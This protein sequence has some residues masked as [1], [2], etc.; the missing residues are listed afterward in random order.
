[1]PAPKI[2]ILYSED[3]PDTREIV[4][5]LLAREGFETVCPDRSQ[6]VLRVAQEEKFDVYLLDTWT[7]IVSGV[8]ICKKI[9]EYDPHTPVI[10]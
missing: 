7:P 5:L 3:D 2:R 10:F 9:R 4:C 1:M 6:D 8:E